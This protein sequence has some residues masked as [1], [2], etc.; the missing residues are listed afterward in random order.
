MQYRRVIG[1]TAP[2]LMQAAVA[3]A[4]LDP[5]TLQVMAVLNGPVALI[6]VAA[7]L[8]GATIVYFMSR[9]FE[10]AL[11]TL[12]TLAIGGLLCSQIQPLARF[13]FP[14]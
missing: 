13:F 6:M 9:D 5:V 7:G 4:T 3:H 12:G 10:R 8:V 11:I 14:G 2:L 1:L